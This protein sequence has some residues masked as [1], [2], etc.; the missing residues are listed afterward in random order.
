MRLTF[1]AAIGL[2]SLHVGTLTESQALPTTGPADAGVSAAALPRPK[3]YRFVDFYRR[4]KGAVA[5]NWKPV[6]RRLPS[7]STRTG[8]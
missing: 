7:F 8:G 5:A 3:S 1:I 4:F 2:T 6:P